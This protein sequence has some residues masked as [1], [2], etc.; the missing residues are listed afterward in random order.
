M[1]YYNHFS[2]SDHGSADL[3]N[4]RRCVLPHRT[5]DNKSSTRLHPNSRTPETP[6]IVLVL[7]RKSSL[8][9][10]TSMTPVVRPN[11]CTLCR[12]I[13][14]GLYCTQYTSPYGDSTSVRA[15]F[16]FHE[17]NVFIHGPI[18][19]YQS[20]PT[21][22]DVYKLYSRNTKLGRVGNVVRL[23]LNDNWSETLDFRLT[24]WSR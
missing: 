4:P 7:L 14:M 24:N 15:S 12:I 16:V 13:S 21:K 10:V 2:E 17:T 5:W 22:L 18:H 11:I 1:S 3:R 6:V 20:P 23:G 8:L 9:L 19:Y